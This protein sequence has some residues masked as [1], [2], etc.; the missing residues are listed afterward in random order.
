MEITRLT[1][2]ELGTNCYV[3]ES[4]TGNAAVIDPADDAEAILRE[5]EKNDAELQLILLTHGHFDHTGAVAE[6]KEKTGA[7]V[8]IHEKDECMTD[9]TI[10]NVAYLSP[11]YEYKPFTADVLLT[12]GDIINLAEIEFSVMNT[13]GH[14]AGSVMYFAEDC[15]FAGD[16]IFEGSIG[17]TDFYS[18]DYAEQRKS[19]EKIAALTDDYK[20]YPGHGGSTTLK[21]EKL[22]N[23]FLSHSDSD[24]F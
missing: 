8:Y 17:R 10:K 9:D 14:T 3:V 19:L 18:G 12:G 22:Y 11:G 24:I 15:I 1:L 7:R 20:I 21:Q 2:G 4:V 16:T 13:P 5:L 23:P 6:L